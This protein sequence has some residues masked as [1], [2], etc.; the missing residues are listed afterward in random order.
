MARKR[1]PRHKNLSILLPAW[2]TVV[3]DGV[4]MFRAQAW[5]LK[6]ARLHGVKFT[7]NS[8]D[9]RRG[10]AERYGK[11]SQWALYDGWV[12]RR[13]GYFPANPPGFSAHELKSDG[14]SFYGP[15]GKSIPNYKLAIDAVDRPGGD[16]K[17]L[18]AWLNRHGYS[19][20]RPYSVLSERHHFSFTK[21]PAAN[22]RRRLAAHYAG[23]KHK[24]SHR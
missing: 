2:E 1:V 6:D 11:Q 18:V 13:P 22:A 23:R 5:A 8:A 17:A 19:A 16:A 20:R 7:V 9:R 14:H 3:F 10:V 21:S 15:R 24:G 4:P 12:K